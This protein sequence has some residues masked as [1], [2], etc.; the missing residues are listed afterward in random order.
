[1][2]NPEREERRKPSR[3]TFLLQ[4]AATAAGFMVSAYLVST[5]IF[6]YGP[7]QNIAPSVRIAV[8]VTALLIT[9]GVVLGLAY[10]ASRGYHAWELQDGKL[11]LFKRAGQAPARSIALEEIASVK[12]R[13]DD[14]DVIARAE[15]DDL[16]AVGLQE[17][18]GD[19]P[20]EAQRHRG[21]IEIFA[22]GTL[23]VVHV[24]TPAEARN[25]VAA[26]EAA[27]AKAAGK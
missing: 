27:R 14:W 10:A 23:F 19:L 24:E 21:E 12:A 1:M 11:L 17:T 8:S 2:G 15:G 26:I 5:V 9:L 3:V 6:D 16:E 20:G 25:G 22:G 7:S 4:F 18:G 13:E